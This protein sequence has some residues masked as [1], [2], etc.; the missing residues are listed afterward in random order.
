VAVVLAYLVEAQQALAAAEGAQEALMAP[1]LP[2]AFTVAALGLAGS[3]VAA[4]FVFSGPVTLVH[5]QLP[6]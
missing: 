6:A 3:A 1:L 4:Q 5:S 2:V